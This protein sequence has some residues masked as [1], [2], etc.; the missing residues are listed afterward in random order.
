MVNAV[1]ILTHGSLASLGDAILFVILHSLEEGTIWLKLCPAVYGA[2]P[3]LE[4][5]LECISD[6]E[7][8]K[9]YVNPFG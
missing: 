1:P 4:N 7:I 8:M 5:G 9:T 2:F 6:F 3:K